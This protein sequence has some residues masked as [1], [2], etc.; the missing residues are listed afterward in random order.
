MVLF[1]LYTP[2]MGKNAGTNYVICI[3]RTRLEKNPKIQ[4]T[5]VSSN[6]PKY[7]RYDCLTACIERSDS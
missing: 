7:L 1:K 2:E 5:P 4:V 6:S 3:V